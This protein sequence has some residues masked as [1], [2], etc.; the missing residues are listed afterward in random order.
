M[1][2]EIILTAVMGIAV[3]GMLWHTVHAC[4]QIME[5]NRALPQ[6]VQIEKAGK[7]R[8]RNLVASI[9]L[10]VDVHMEYEAGKNDADGYEPGHD[11]LV[12]RDVQSRD[13][14]FYGENKAITT[15]DH[16]LFDDFDPDDLLQRTVI[17]ELVAIAELSRYEDVPK[18]LKKK[19]KH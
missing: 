10:T 2:T 7:K 9:D 1:T 15:L 12:V 14:N 8:H 16:E 18:R 13:K 6:I 4:I 3:G 11:Y 17:R 19:P 5:R